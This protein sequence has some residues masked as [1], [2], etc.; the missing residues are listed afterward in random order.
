MGS[1]AG[2]AGIDDH[3][4]AVDGDGAFGNVGGE[5][6]FA[7]LIGSDG[8][9]L[10]FGCEVAVERREEE[11]VAFGKACERGGGAADFV[12]AGEED[13]EVAGGRLGEDGFHRLAD[14]V[15]ERVGGVRAVAHVHGEQ[16]AFGAKDRA[17]VEIGGDGRGVEGGGHDDELEVRA[18]GALEVAEKSEGEVGVEVAFVELVEDDEG[19]GVEARVGEEAAGE[20]AFGEEA[21]ARVAAAGLFEAH[22]VA[23][24]IAEGLTE[25]FG[26]A[27]RGEAGSEAAGFQNPDF[28]LRDGEKRGWN[29]G[30]FSCAWRRLQDDVGVLL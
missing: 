25:F 6:D 1:D 15:F 14:L 19:G 28:P 5:D 9:V 26:D 7:L 24:G 2:E 17:A 23:D 11:V 4:N 22:L 3:G 18:G 27:A 10:F 8:A 30:G 21:E 13:E 16:A 12:G 20:D 29:A